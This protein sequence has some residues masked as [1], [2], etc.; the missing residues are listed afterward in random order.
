MNESQLISSLRKSGQLQEAYQRARQALQENPDDLSLPRAMGWVLYDLVKRELG[1]VSDDEGEPSR[2]ASVDLR[3]VHRFFHEFQRLGIPRDDHLIYSL[4]LRLATKAQRA[5]WRGFLEFVQW[6]DLSH[7]TEEDRQP[8]Q[9]AGDKQ[10]P[11]LESVALYAIGRAA[12]ESEDASERVWARTVLE[13]AVARYPDDIWIARSLAHLEF[14]DGNLDRAQE[15][16]RSVL[17]RKPRE[18]WLWKEMGE[19]LATTHPDDAIL[20]YYRACE[21]MRDKTK[22]VSVYQQLA[23]LLA[24]QGRYDEAAWFVE[25]AYSIRAQQGWKIPPELAQMHSDEWFQARQGAPKPQAQTDGFAR[26]FLQGI[27]A[28]QVQTALAVLD[29]HNSQKQ[30]AYLLTAPREGVAVP[31]KQFPKVQNLSV[32]AMVELR[33]AHSN[34]RRVIVEVKPASVQEIEGFAKRVRGRLRKPANQSYGF[35]QADTGEQYFAPPQVAQTLQDG[36]DVEAVC[37]LK[38]NEKRNREDWVAICLDTA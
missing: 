14:S 28:E 20:C 11:S 30:L 31:Y 6:W 3:R 19:M 38:H 21:L 23:S 12:T 13:D 26:Q 32:G 2:Q 33:Y 29:H 15:R 8:Q 37:V 10:I 17:R 36:A 4:M 9:I 16:L 18:W 35:V 34:G 25:Q 24:S 1:T 5:G 7:L 22:L 27:A